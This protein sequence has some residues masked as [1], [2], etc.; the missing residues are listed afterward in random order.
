MLISSNIKRHFLRA[1]A[2][3]FAK[4]STYTNFVS[5]YCSISCYWKV[6]VQQIWHNYVDLLVDW[7][8]LC[9]DSSEGQ[10]SFGITPVAYKQFSQVLRL[11]ATRNQIMRYANDKH[12]W[13][14]KVN[15]AHSPNFDRNNKAGTIFWR[16]TNT[17]ML[18]FAKNYF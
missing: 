13:P 5:F 7:I 17:K 8:Q 3:Y 4:P 14:V 16:K 12:G 1:S 9:G 2:N 6:L 10:R 18:E 15:T 11:P